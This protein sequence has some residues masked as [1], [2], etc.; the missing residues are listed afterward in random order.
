MN[1][2][3]RTQHGSVLVFALVLVAV[4]ATLCLSFST[5]MTADEVGMESDIAGSQ[6]LQLA[7]SASIRRCTS[8]KS[9]R[10]NEHKPPP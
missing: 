8:V 4:L 5:R 6:A 7:Q 10:Q 3:K 1:A 9:R 2:I